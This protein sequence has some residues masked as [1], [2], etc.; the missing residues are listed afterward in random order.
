VNFEDRMLV[1]LADP[2]TRGGVFDQPALEAIVDAGY[3]AATMGLG[4]PFQA[5]FD[6]LR[7]GLAVPPIATA[8][9]MWRPTGGAE[10]TD[11]RLQVS[12]LGADP[13]IRVDALWLGSIVARFALVGEPIT[14]TSVNWSAAGRIDAEI[15]AA[16]GALPADRGVLEQARRDRLLAHIQAGLDQPAAFGDPDLQRWLSSVGA[17][18]ASDLLEHMLGVADGAALKV[19]FAAPSAVADTPAPL[20]IAAPILIRDSTGFSLTQLLSD[21]KSIRE[22]V[23][24]MGTARPQANGT[25]PRQS[26]IVVWVLPQSLFDDPDWPGAQD[27]QA[28]DQARAARRAVASNWLADEGVGLVAAPDQP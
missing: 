20:A 22:R 5:V 13:T 16:Q 10:Q 26:V 7:L 21:S 14:E 24:A 12:G 19:T 27:G 3:D 6:E 17:G 1:A 11:V 28:A 15:V 2:A 4:G 8:D 9:G 23:L 18:S 25:R